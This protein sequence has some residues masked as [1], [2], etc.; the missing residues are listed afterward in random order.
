M[1]G[2]DRCVVLVYSPEPWRWCRYM[3][4]WSRAGV[5]YAVA[6][7]L[8]GGAGILSLLEDPTGYNDTLLVVTDLAGLAAH[9]ANSFVLG[10]RDR[11]EVALLPWALWVP[12]DGW[13]PEVIRD[14]ETSRRAWNE[15]GW[16]RLSEHIDPHP[17]QLVAWA[18]GW[19]AARDAGSLAAE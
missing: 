10:E 19:W 7:Q 13:T 2:G 3:R 11:A 17:L 1:G 6:T 18:A 12:G 4:A 8:V 5:E 14:S 15:C 9:A 16:P